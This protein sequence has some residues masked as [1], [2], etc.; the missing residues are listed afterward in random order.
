VPQNLDPT[1]DSGFVRPYVEI[2]A[3]AV[4]DKSGRSNMSTY[5]DTPVTNLSTG[6]SRRTASTDTTS[7]ENPFFSEDEGRQKSVKSEW[8][9][10]ALRTQHETMVSIDSARGLPNGPRERLTSSQ[11]ANIPWLKGTMTPIDE[12]RGESP[13]ENVGMANLGPSR[14]GLSRIKSIGKVPQ[15]RTPNPVRGRVR[16]GSISIEPIVVPPLDPRLE[17]E[18]VYGSASTGYGEYG[19]GA[20]RD[21]EVLGMEE[22]YDGT[23]Y[24]IA[25]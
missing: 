10:E 22:Q 6:F 4:L 16:T 12:T 18:L 14:P 21:S 5:S 24:A 19:G 7:T 23:Y 2:P 1:P 3:P 25:R 13:L 17:I 11:I 15:R 9:D 20:L 8:I